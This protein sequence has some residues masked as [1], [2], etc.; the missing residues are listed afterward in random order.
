MI[1]KHGTPPTVAEPTSAPR[2]IHHGGIAVDTRW[3]AGRPAIIASGS[4]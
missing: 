4:R 3:R 2:L 1:L